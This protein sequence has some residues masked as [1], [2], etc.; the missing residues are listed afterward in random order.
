MSSAGISFDDVA[1]V[2]DLLA[3]YCHIV[4]DGAFERLGEVFADDGVFVLRG[5]EHRGLPALTAMYETIQSAER[6][7]VH[8]LGLPVLDV[9]GDELT[10]T[11][12]VAF[13]TRAEAGWQV[14]TVGRYRD[15]LAR[16]A[17]GWRILRREF[18]A[19]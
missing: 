14:S 17:S 16:T 12:D 18:V 4:D 2:H 7:G 9:D 15:R 11:T 8:I 1:G 13:H 5:G 10:A 19:R 3:R 6:R